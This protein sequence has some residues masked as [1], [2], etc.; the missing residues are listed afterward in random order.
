MA[1][2]VLGLGTSHSPHVSTQPEDWHL[3]AER[4]Y[5]NP[6]L[7]MPALERAAPAGV[8][9][10]LTLETYRAKHATTQRA[11][12]DLAATLVNARPDVVLVVGDDQHELFLEEC[13]PA[14]AVFTGAAVVD[15]PPD[16]ATVVPSHQVALWSRHKGVRETYPAHPEFAAHLTRSLCTDDFDIATAATQFAERSIGHAYTFVRLRLLADAVIPIVPVFINCYFPP[17]QPAPTRCYA[18]GTALRRAIE[19]W[20]GD[21]RVALVASGGLSHFVIDEELDRQLLRGISEGRSELIAGLPAEKLVSGTSEIRNWIA[22][23]AAM[24]HTPVQSVVYEPCYRTTAGTGCGMA[25][26][27]WNPAAS[28]A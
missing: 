24:E 13:S 3:H 11:I 19:S 9:T 16:P 14:F 7:D 26:V 25:F 27:V 18:F 15:V 21:L 22:V 28:A 5:K 8:A 12:A 17:N 1:R 23:A 20:P 10:Q 4:D 6:R 2:I